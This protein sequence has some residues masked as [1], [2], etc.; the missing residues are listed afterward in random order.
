MLINSLLNAAPRRGQDIV[1]NGSWVYDALFDLELDV[2]RWHFI[3]QTPLTIQTIKGM[4]KELP[5]EKL[6]DSGRAQYERLQEYFGEFDFSLDVGIF[7]VGLEPKFNLEGYFKSNSSLDWLYN[8][9]ERQRL[10]E[11]PVRLTLGDYLTVYMGL[12]VG[13][14]RSYMSRTYNYVNH[15]FEEEAFDPNLTHLTYI[16]TGYQWKNGVGFSFNMGYGTQNF[17]RASLGSIIMSD[18]LS[19]LPYGQLRVYSPV[20]TYSFNVAQLNPKTTMYTHTIDIR[21]FKKFTVGFMEGGAAYNCFDMKFLNPFGIFHGYELNN[22]YDWISYMG[23]KFNFVPVRN[24]RFYFN[25]A[26]NEHQ[27]ASEQRSGPGAL[28]EGKGFQGGVNFQFPVKG[29]FLRFNL[30]GYYATPYLWIKQSPNWSLVGARGDITSSEY[31]YDW[32]GSPVGP[33]SI[34][35]K[36]T[37]AYEKPGKWGVELNYIFAARGEFSS[38]DIFKNYNWGVGNTDIDLDE[39]WIYVDNPAYAYGREFKTPHGTAEYDNII[40]IRG[41]Y[42]PTKWLTLIAQPA[43]IFAFNAGHEEGNFEQGFEM[44]LSCRFDFCRIPKKPVNFSFLTKDRIDKESAASEQ[45]SAPILENGAEAASS[46]AE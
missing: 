25:I 40:Y 14:R 20:F 34:S 38:F 46:E 15:I 6:S 42:S 10:L 37:A 5:V 11:A 44:A 2:G 17:G 19:D 16:S 9:H 12:A 3:D 43:Y 13:Q 7:S 28:P 31:E 41:K 36:F 24:L 23:V 8:Y 26:Q 29:G 39:N 32:I 27:I 22:Q 33:D 21:L 45:P 35:G 4:L 30:E 18:Y 1:P